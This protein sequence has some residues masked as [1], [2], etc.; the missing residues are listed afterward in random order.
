MVAG[1]LTLT[2]FWFF[3]YA[4]KTDWLPHKIVPIAAIVMGILGVVWLY[5]ELT[6]RPAVP[7]IAKGSEPAMSVV[8]P[9]RLRDSRVEPL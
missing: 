9:R 3:V 4:W 8:P 6:D 1:V 5:D 7:S 2:P